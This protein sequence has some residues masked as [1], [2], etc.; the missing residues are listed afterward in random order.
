MG[1]ER[2]GTQ[3]PHRRPR[4]VDSAAGTPPAGRRE[5]GQQAEEEAGPQAEEEAGPQAEW[6]LRWTL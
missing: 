5:A 6:R 1:L 3:A 2:A 4:I